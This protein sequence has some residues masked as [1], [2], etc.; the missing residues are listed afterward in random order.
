MDSAERTSS[1]QETLEGPSSVEKPVSDSA[2]VKVQRTR[3][4]GFLPI[5]QRLRF[6]EGRPQTFGVLLQLTFAAA[7]TFTVTNLYY[8][9]PL[10]ITLA[11]A[12]NVDHSEVSRLNNIT[13]R[14][15]VGL[16]LVTPLGDLV[17]RRPLLLFLVLC[18]A[19]LS[20]GLAVTKSIVVFEVLSFF[21]GVATVT[22]QVLLP[23]A[24]DLA[25]PQRRATAISVVFSGLLF[26]ILLAR[27]LAG[28]IADFSS[29]R[30]VYIMALGVQY[31][32]LLLLYFVLPDYPAKSTGLTYF[33]I[34][35][36]MAWFSVTEPIL[37][38]GCIVSCASSATFSSFWVTVCYISGLPCSLI[39]GLFG[40]IGMLGVMTA[41][42][43]GRFIDMLVPWNASVLATFI[44]FFFQ[45]IQTGGGGISIAAVIIACFGLDV[46]RQ[47][48]QVS[49]SS[50][51]F[52]IDPNARARLNAVYIFTGQ[53]MGTAAG[54]MV[55]IRHG[56][57]AAA[58]LSLA[59]MVFQFGIM[60]LR[61]PHVPRKQWVGW[62]GG[63]S[64]R[65]RDEEPLSAGDAEKGDSVTDDEKKQKEQDSTA[66]VPQDIADPD[67][68][69]TKR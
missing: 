13:P 68:K 66:D 11:Q 54:T 41:P 61:G 39:T 37:I 17:H 3:D 12:F 51:I 47:M 32:I 26:G 7:T 58:L 25:P 42:L 69:D 30:N 19:S 49:L 29:F 27:V 52:G 56:W 65:R 38:Q 36:S 4:F 8:C 14:Y 20:I 55:F 63:W 34:L 35:K 31:L 9:Q 15:A 57:R 67:V 18:S 33:G 43:V 40:L 1:P 45:T 44:M 53:L 23:L 46:G 10:L 2:P 5:P 24:A 64:L 62:Q 6:Y 59:W 21:V 50:A 28:V 48:Q 22:P 60:F 16:L